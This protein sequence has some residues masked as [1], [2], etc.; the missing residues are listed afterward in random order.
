MH[1]NVNKLI[2]DY[3]LSVATTFDL[4]SLVTECKMIELRNAGLKNLAREVLGKE[5]GKPKSV[6]Q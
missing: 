5:I 1:T 3:A 4:C 2:E 6:G